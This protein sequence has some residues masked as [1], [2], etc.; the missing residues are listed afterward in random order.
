MG[1][2]EP[3]TF[4]DSRAAADWAVAKTKIPG[5]IRVPPTEVESHLSEIPRDRR[6]IVYCA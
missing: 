6:I 5:A 2:G 4:L 1:A 3:L